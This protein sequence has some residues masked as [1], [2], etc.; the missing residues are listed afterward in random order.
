MPCGPP[1]QWEGARARADSA[2]LAVPSGGLASL[3]LCLCACLCLGCGGGLR[4]GTEETKRN[5]GP[6]RETVANARATSDSGA[7]RVPSGPSLLYIATSTQSWNQEV[8]LRPLDAPREEIVVW[9]SPGRRGRAGLLYRSLSRE[10]LVWWGEPGSALSVFLVPLT[11]GRTTQV[12][13]DWDVL[14]AVWG[15]PSTVEFL[16]QDMTEWTYDLS[17]RRTSR[18]RS[19]VNAW[20]FLESAF[21]EPIS[22][23]RALLRAKKMPPWMDEDEAGLAVLRGAGLPRLPPLASDIPVIG[24]VAAVSPDAQWVAYYGRDEQ[25]ISVVSASNGGLYDVI[26]LPAEA[27]GEFVWVDDL[28]WSAD[29]RWLTFTEVH[30]RPARYYAPDLPGPAPEPGEWTNLVRL[31]GRQAK[32][33]VTLAEGRSGVVITE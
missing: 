6:V 17:A 23:V 25:A 18:G 13:R 11:G 31:Y 20:R 14:S 7:V 3:C 12:G 16:T 27:R 30:N 5:R 2:G 21:S 29:S 4:P 8:R 1:D 10:V 26:A 15:G 9:R 28:C 32:S 22:V 24:S 19:G 33:V